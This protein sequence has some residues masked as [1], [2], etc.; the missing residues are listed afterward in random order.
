MKCRTKV[1]FQPTTAQYSDRK[2][3]MKQCT[4][5]HFISQSCREYEH[6]FS[7]HQSSSTSGAQNAISLFVCVFLRRSFYS[8]TEKPNDETSVMCFWHFQKIPHVI[9]NLGGLNLHPNRRC[10]QL[11]QAFSFVLQGKNKFKR[12]NLHPPPLYLHFHI[13]PDAGNSSPRMTGDFEQ[14]QWEDMQLLGINQSPRL[15]VG[16]GQGVPVPLLFP[17]ADLATF[18]VPPVQ[19]IPLQQR[20]FCQCNCLS[21]VQRLPNMLIIFFTSVALYCQT[22]QQSLENKS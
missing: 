5:V 4:E 14:R 3:T 17:K 15:S 9:S 7:N 22:I 16:G 8:F 13:L 11:T 21:F 2:Q 18:D 19:T 6:L 20:H 1:P 12:E 10:V